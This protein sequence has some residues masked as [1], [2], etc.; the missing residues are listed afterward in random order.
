MTRYMKEFSFLTPS[1]MGTDYERA[2]NIVGLPATEHGYGFVHCVDDDG[3]RWTHV[4]ADP[5]ALQNLLNSGQR[6][7]LNDRMWTPGSPA[8]ELSTEMFSQS[9][10]GW[11]DDWAIGTSKR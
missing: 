10:Q 2:C 1:H 6:V 9:R 3:A 5:Q 4:T 8:P 7:E 11:P